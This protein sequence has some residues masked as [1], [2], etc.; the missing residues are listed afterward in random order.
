MSSHAPTDLG[1]EVPDAT[2]PGPFVTLRVVSSDSG[3]KR[4]WQSRHHRK[5]LAD[6]SALESE[7]VTRIL[8]RCLWMPG[9]LNWWIGTIFAIGSVCFATASLLA[10]LPQSPISE[11]TINRI[12]FAGSIPFTLAAWLQLYQAA[13]VLPAPGDNANG[14]PPHPVRR[15]LFGWNPKNIGW[16]SCAL[17]FVGT[18]LFNV[19]TY[20]AMSTSLSWVEVDLV[21]WI[22]NLVGS[23]LFLLSGYLAFIE[24]CHTFW[25]WR[26]ASLTWWVVFINLLGCVGFMI[27]ALFAPVFSETP[28]PF[29]T[30]VSLAFTLQGA[31]CFFVGAIL[32]LPETAIKAEAEAIAEKEPGEHDTNSN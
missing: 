6:P 4:V 19:N 32:M 27:S 31:L 16:L 18:L 11:A 23:V 3:K 24:T 13:N 7:T 29:A 15:K 1:V 12:F 21:V 14:G 17:Q 10:L 5:R 22:P 2:G 26:H 9:E 20:N 28:N 25:A 8:R 30:T